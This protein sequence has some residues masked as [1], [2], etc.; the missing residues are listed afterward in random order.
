MRALTNNLFYTVRRYVTN[1]VDN[2]GMSITYEFLGQLVLNGYLALIFLLLLFCDYFY[3]YSY[4]RINSMPLFLF[5]VTVTMSN[6]Y[7]QNFAMSLGI[8]FFE[9][10]LLT[11]A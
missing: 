1:Q 9:Q 4:H 11:S 6:D 8:C 10:I 7:V 5:A 2:T 3:D